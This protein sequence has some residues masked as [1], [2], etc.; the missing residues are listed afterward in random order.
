MIKQPFLQRSYV[1]VGSSRR[2]T[3]TAA[4][5]RSGLYDRPAGQKTLISAKSI[6]ESQEGTIKSVRLRNQIISSD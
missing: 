4:L 3:I 2:T 6:L 5:Y 1:K